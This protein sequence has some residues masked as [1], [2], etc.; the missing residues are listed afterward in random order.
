MHVCMVCCMPA[1]FGCMHGL[2]H[3]CFFGTYSYVA[4]MVLVCCMHAVGLVHLWYR[5]CMCVV[6]F[7]SCA[8]DQGPC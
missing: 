8:K 5:C 6:G 3:A 4:C 7:M 1:L 2:L